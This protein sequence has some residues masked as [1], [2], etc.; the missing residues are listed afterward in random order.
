[1]EPLKEN[2]LTSVESLFT[3]IFAFCRPI[4]A[5]KRPIPTETACFSVI[6]MELKIASRTLVRESRIKMIPSTKTATRACCQE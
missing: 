2:M 6:G 3:T 5:M 4:N 1:M